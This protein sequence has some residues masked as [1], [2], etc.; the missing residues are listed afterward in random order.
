MDIQRL[1]ATKR[2]GN[3]L[4]CARPMRGRKC[5]RADI[6]ATMRLSMATDMRGCLSGKNPPDNLVPK[7]HNGVFKTDVDET[8]RPA[9]LGIAFLGLCH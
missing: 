7:G 9:P 5:N 4:L 1:L 8:T 2:S 3:P 6:L